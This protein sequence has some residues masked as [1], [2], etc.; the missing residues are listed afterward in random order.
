MGEI[1]CVLR[2]HPSVAAAVVVVREEEGDKQV[3]AYV[4]PAP[5]GSAPQEAEWHEFLR[6]KLPD[7]MVPSAFVVLEK[8]PLDPEWQD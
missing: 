5:L 7:Y 4:V 2:E 8:L 1:Q 3:V 6:K